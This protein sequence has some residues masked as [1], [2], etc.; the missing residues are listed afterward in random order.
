MIN[1]LE[2]SICR[3]TSSKFAVGGGHLNSKMID[4]WCNIFVVDGHVIMIVLTELFL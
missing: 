1:G 3:G 2:I 4:A